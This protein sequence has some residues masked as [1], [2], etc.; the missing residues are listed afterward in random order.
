MKY[1]HVF[2]W[3]Y[4]NFTKQKR[5]WVPNKIW[6]KIGRKICRLND[7]RFAINLVVNS[8]I[9]C[10]SEFVLHFLITAI[11]TNCLTFRI[12]TCYVHLFESTLESSSSSIQ[13]FLWYPEFNCLSHNR[14]LTINRICTYIQ[15][16]RSKNVVAVA[17]FFPP[18]HDNLWGANNPTL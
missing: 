11:F 8:F 13:S 17:E 16:W 9:S 12:S 14:E 1:I 10:V 7:C 2:P 4:W 15:A 6:E 18:M 3:Y 5:R